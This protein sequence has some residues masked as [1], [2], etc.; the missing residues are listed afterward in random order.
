MNPGLVQAQF[1]FTSAPFASCHAATLIQTKEGLTAAF[2]GG[3]REGSPDVRIWQCSYCSGKWSAPVAVADG[4]QTPD[5]S[6]APA[7]VAAT[8]P[9]GPT[10]F[11][12]WNPIL[13]Q[14]RGCVMRLF[15]KV[16]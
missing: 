15:F 9:A 14:A 2:F 6:T 16:G 3:S 4:V 8:Q 11:A 13:F 1:L 5:S 10:R 7:T 12:C